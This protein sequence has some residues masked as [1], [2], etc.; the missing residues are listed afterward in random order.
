MHTK[1]PECNL[2][3]TPEELHDASLEDHLEYKRITNDVIKDLRHKLAKAMEALK[4]LQKTCP[5][6]WYIDTVEK[7][8]KEIGHE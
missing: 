6:N 1:C 8:L 3:F 7:A 5:T 2:T 4:T